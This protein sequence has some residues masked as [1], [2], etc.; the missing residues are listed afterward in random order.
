[1]VSQH[2]GRVELGRLQRQHHRGETE[3][4]GSSNLEALGNLHSPLSVPSILSRLCAQALTPR[5]GLPNIYPQNYSKP[6]DGMI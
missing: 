2:Q 1:M 6:S 3:M 5:V 4:A